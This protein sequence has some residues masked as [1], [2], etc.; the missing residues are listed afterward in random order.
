[1]LAMICPNCRSS[2][3]RRS[4]RNVAERFVLP[5]VFRRPFRCEDCISRFYGWVWAEGSTATN[6]EN[7]ESPSAQAPSA[8]LHSG[9]HRR[10]WRRTIK[11]HLRAEPWNRISGSVASWLKKPIQTSSQLPMNQLITSPA[12]VTEAAPNENTSPIPQPPFQPEVLAVI[13]EI[14]R[15]DN[16][17]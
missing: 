11:N 12:S 13:V 4:K 7:S 9:F 10:R 8:A 3:I 14:K 15:E 6:R 17:N 2:F 1:M 16:T 5:L